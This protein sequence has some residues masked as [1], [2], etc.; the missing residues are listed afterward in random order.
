ML[1]AAVLLTPPLRQSPVAVAGDTSVSFTDLGECVTFL[2]E[3]ANTWST[4]LNVRPPTIRYLEGGEDVAAAFYRPDTEE[5]FLRRCVSLPILAHELGHHVLQV[6]AGSWEQHAVEAA[7]FCRGEGCSDGWVPEPVMAG[8]EHAAH[9]IGAVILKEF[10]PYTRCKFP[11][12]VER[13]N[14]IAHA[15]IDGSHTHD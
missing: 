8:S 15:H 4:E 11:D 14:E 3:Q 13:A 9:C 7:F 10:T 5:L 12:M 2:T 1:A 6:H